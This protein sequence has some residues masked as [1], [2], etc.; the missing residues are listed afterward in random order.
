MSSYSGIERPEAKAQWSPKQPSRLAPASRCSNSSAR[1][2]TDRP[3]KPAVRRPYCGLDCGGLP[4][5]DGGVL[6]LLLG[7]RDDAEQKA[8]LLSQR[9]P[10]HHRRLRAGP[11]K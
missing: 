1:R 3:A 11:K 10:L 9:P 8:L 6:E 2:G 7:D 4:D 5:G